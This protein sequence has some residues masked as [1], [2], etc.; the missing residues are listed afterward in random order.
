VLKHVFLK[1]EIQN[2]YEWRIIIYCL[3][4]DNILFQLN[5]LSAKNRKSAWW[6]QMFLVD[7]QLQRAFRRH[8]E[9]RH[10]AAEKKLP[11]L[12][13]AR[14]HRKMLWNM[15]EICEKKNCCLKNLRQKEKV[16]YHQSDD[17]S[18]KRGYCFAELWRK[19]MVDDEPLVLWLE[20]IDWHCK[21]LAERISPLNLYWRADL[22]YV[23]YEICMVIFLRVTV[24]III[25]LHCITVSSKPK[26]K[27]WKA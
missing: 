14:C 17:I 8:E 16:I 18:Q 11:I 3:Y 7:A 5:T 13:N 12:K 6:I 20:L 25:T 15:Q 27:S 2:F 1:Q 4:F 23:F 22:Y 26:A 10:Q 19:T 24:V 21:C 9:K